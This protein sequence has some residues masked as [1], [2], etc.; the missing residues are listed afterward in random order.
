MEYFEATFLC[1][2]KAARRL[3]LE[4]GLGNDEWNVYIEEV[5]AE[6][7]DFESK[8]TSA[9]LTLTTRPKSRL[10]SRANFLRSK[11]SSFSLL[12]QKMAHPTLHAMKG[13]THDSKTCR[14]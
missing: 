12:R 2:G 6:T 5:N 11:A 10:K 14:L 13:P 4:E 3:T 8:S 7:N 1:E 9:S